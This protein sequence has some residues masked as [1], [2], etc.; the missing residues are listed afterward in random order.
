MRETLRVTKN[1]LDALQLEHKK[2]SLDLVRFKNGAMAKQWELATHK[3]LVERD[4]KHSEHVGLLLAERAFETAAAECTVTVKQAECRK[5]THREH[6]VLDAAVAAAA[7]SQAL[8]M[9]A[10]IELETANSPFGDHGMAPPTASPA[11][12]TNH[13][14]DCASPQTRNRAVA[15]LAFP[16]TMPTPRGARSSPRIAT[17]SPTIATQRDLI[18]ETLRLQKMELATMVATRR[19][20]E[21][22][23]ETKEV[24]AALESLRAGDADPS[25][26]TAL[27]CHLVKAMLAGSDDAKS[28]SLNLV[29]E[30]D[31][32][33]RALGEWGFSIK[34]PGRYSG[35][36]GGYGGYEYVSVS[37][38]PN[39]VRTALGRCFLDGSDDLERTRAAVAFAGAFDSIRPFLGKTLP[40][41]M[42]R[43]VL[44]PRD[45]EG[46]QTA[47]NAVR[48]LMMNGGFNGIDGM[49]ST[50]E[51]KSNANDNASSAFQ[52]PLQNE[53]D[54]WQTSGD[55]LA[56][57]LFRWS[58]CAVREWRL[59]V[60]VD[61]ATQT[62]RSVDETDAHADADA[63][64]DE[65]TEKKRMH[66]TLL[67]TS[68]RRKSKS[69][70]IPLVVR[71]PVSPE[72]ARKIARHGAARVLARTHE[73]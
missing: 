64:S 3:A 8:H 36:N 61:D 14:G 39:S 70:R 4:L 69:R 72:D 44:D 13:T 37:L 50:S 59:R 68:G 66:E 16:S 40:Q 5:E 31:V 22:A 47:T 45:T 53:T 41:R 43:A 34:T 58:A 24:L 54:T 57:L 33:A 12:V 20:L 65:E 73:R 27:A 19:A 1:E 56:Q 42:Q 26:A 10:Q 51:R 35:G 71:A 9:E 23:L 2:L 6:L 32:A 30:E 62:L 38:S 18:M 67:D 29:T 25:P 11:R 15:F 7:R 28:D 46:L 48:V 63:S 55:P 52:T 21:L 49:T 17:P 60:K